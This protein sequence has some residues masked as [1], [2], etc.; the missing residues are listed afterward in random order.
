MYMNTNSNFE[1]TLSKT[2]KIV[3]RADNEWEAIFDRIPDLLVITNA[4]GIILRCN[5]STINKL[6]VEFQTILGSNI[7]SFF[8]DRKDA[9]YT[10]R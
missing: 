10:G 1:Q 8:S 7:S 4:S 9:K 3:L 6:K 2:K 5:R